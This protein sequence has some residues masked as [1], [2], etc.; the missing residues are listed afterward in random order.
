[1]APTTFTRLNIINAA[2]LNQ[3][4]TE[5]AAENDGS[6][7]WRTLAAQWAMIVEGEMEDAAMAHQIVEEE[8][9]TRDGSGSFGYTSAYATPV[10][11]LHVRRVFEWD[12]VEGS[13]RT[14]HDDW[15]QDAFSIHVNAD[16]G[17]WAEFVEVVEPTDFGPNFARGIQKKLE[18]VIARAIKEEHPLADRLEQEA[19]YFLQ[20]ARTSASAGKGVKPL[21]RPSSKFT[22]ARFQR[23]SWRNRRG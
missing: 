10:D 19:E 22:E 11:A 15:Y 18:A 5:L 21:F 4:Q 1:M 20:R 8:I 17:I 23:G 16:T 14:Y 3:G 12:G 13:V 7:E 6:L 2:L 9:A